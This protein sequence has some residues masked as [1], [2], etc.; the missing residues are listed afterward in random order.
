M[1]A[2]GASAWYAFRW[3][4][5]T[6]ARV[7]GF[8][9]P[10]TGAGQIIHVLLIVLGVGTL[11]CA[12]ATL[13]ERF[14]GGQLADAL[15][16]RREKLFMRRAPRF[17][18]SAPTVL[19]HRAAAQVRSS[20][21]WAPRPRSSVWSISSRSP[22]RSPRAIAPTAADERMARATTRLSRRPAPRP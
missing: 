15:A 7:G 4:L 17:S 9:Q 1:L 21:R 2:E 19:E 3:T 16:R 10:H 12:L 13:T 18:L 6:V 14:V 20:R 8:P 5:D 11:F 22:A